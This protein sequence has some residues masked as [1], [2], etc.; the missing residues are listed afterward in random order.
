MSEEWEIIIQDSFCAAHWIEGYSGKCA[1]LHG[2]NYNVEI[3]IYVS[4]LNSVGIGIDFSDIKKELKSVIDRM[5]HQC[6]NKLDICSAF[7]EGKTTAE[8]IAKYVFLEL[9]NSFVVNYVKIFETDKY[10]VI[11]RRKK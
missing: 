9:E 1:N 8:N 11:Y 6:L 2:H 7:K 10:S 3:S 5:D 4:E